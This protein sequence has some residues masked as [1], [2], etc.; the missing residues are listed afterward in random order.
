MIPIGTVV[1][2]AG[3]SKELLLTGLDA[4]QEIRTIRI[5]IIL[6]LVSTAAAFA[7]ALADYATLMTATLSRVRISMDQDENSESLTPAEWRTDA[8]DATGR[9]PFQEF[10]RVGSNI[11]ATGN[12]AVFKFPIDVN[13][14]HE[15]LD[16]PNLFTVSS[17]QVN[18]GACK[19]AI[20][21]NGAPGNVVLTNGTAVVTPSDAKVQF[22]FADAHMTFVGPHWTRKVKGAT[23]QYD[24]EE[25]PSVELFLAQETA[26][27]TFEQTVNQISISVDERFKPRNMPPTE[28]AAWYGK[29]A[30][31]HP[32][33]LTAI[34]ITNNAVGGGNGSI[35]T[36]L[37]F[38]NA[39]V[40]A[41]EYE[42]PFYKRKRR[43]EFPSGVSFAYSFM[44]KTTMHISRQSEILRAV[45]GAKQVMGDPSALPVRGFGGGDNNT[46]REFKGRVVKFAA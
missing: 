17:D 26:A 30:V 32:A 16:T 18:A 4:E 37:R 7:M 41:A 14:T 2:S 24:V 19:V 34:D 22:E 40:R 39:R 42:L 1:Y 31:K 35:V 10:L 28:L 20:D 25:F 15:A 45:M 13:Y 6:T 38:L 11:P 33:E 36:P 27:A 5:L 29:V 12:P 3:N 43:V 21:W 46:L 44:R 9:D 8:I 23:A